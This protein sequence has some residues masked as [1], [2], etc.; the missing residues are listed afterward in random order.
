MDDIF[1][2][3]KKEQFN[4]FQKKM[5][6]PKNVLQ[7][8]T[9][10]MIQTPN[11]PCF[12]VPAEEI[13]EEYVQLRLP[14]RVLLGNVPILAYDDGAY[15]VVLEK[16]SPLPPDAT[17]QTNWNYPVWNTD[18]LR[19]LHYTQ[20]ANPWDELKIAGVVRVV[21]P[22]STD[23]KK[24]AKK[25][26]I[27]A[28]ATHKCSWGSIDAA[29]YLKKQEYEP[30]HMPLQLVTCYMPATTTN[31]IELT[32][33]LVSI[34]AGTLFD[35]VS[36]RDYTG[37]GRT[38][39]SAIK[40]GPILV[41]MPH[42]NDKDHTL[43]DR[44]QLWYRLRSFGML[45]LEGS[46]LNAWTCWMVGFQSSSSI[47][48]TKDVPM[49]RKREDDD[50]V[51]NIETYTERVEAQFNGNAGHGWQ[52]KALSELVG[53]SATYHAYH[54]NPTN[55]ICTELIA[56][57][58]KHLTLTHNALAKKLKDKI[59]Q[60]DCDTFE[61]ATKTTPLR[62]VYLFDNDVKT[63]KDNMKTLQDVKHFLHDAKI[64]IIESELYTR[65]DVMN[66]LGFGL[67]DTVR[68]CD[69]TN[70][71]DSNCLVVL[72]NKNDRKAHIYAAALAFKSAGDVIDIRYM[73]CKKGYERYGAP[74][75]LLLHLLKTDDEGRPKHYVNYTLHNFDVLQNDL[76]PCMWYYHEITIRKLIKLSFVGLQFVRGC[77]NESMHLS[78][79]DDHDGVTK[80]NF[81]STMEHFILYKEN[82]DNKIL[83]SK[84]VLDTPLEKISEIFTTNLKSEI[85]QH[86]KELDKNGFKKGILDIEDKNGSVLGPYNMINLVSTQS[87][88]MSWVKFSNPAKPL[89]T[90]DMDESSS[91]IFLTQL[92]TTNVITQEAMLRQLKMVTDG[93]SYL[94][95]AETRKM[96]GRVR[97]LYYGG[98]GGG[99]PHTA[100]RQ[101]EPTRFNASP[102]YRAGPATATMTKTDILVKL[103]ELYRQ[104]EQLKLQWNEMTNLQAESHKKAL[105]TEIFHLNNLL[106][107]Q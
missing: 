62:D 92:D 22:H 80:P 101:P 9:Q 38:A 91:H 35:S 87:T 60:L 46:V 14:K 8:G 30:N 53:D 19:N 58:T 69:F 76:D 100:F 98:L 96:H 13:P 73:F 97:S 65:T 6:D 3:N 88:N 41:E 21:S 31:H 107:N 18:V 49:L 64:M 44:K 43:D 84:E 42:L 11:N 83:K 70:S 7:R 78:S 5:A 48:T 68:T 4:I 10:Y 99:G 20:T 67:I 93:P 77:F 23:G 105:E 40:V 57:E 28:H 59:S 51:Y 56:R 106:L 15:M 32:S 12:I 75:L 63:L 39:S 16:D 27:E 85:Q 29:K 37:S 34:A 72:Y 79:Y 55:E 33:R 61:L 94:K 54:E 71:D 86:I 25:E 17:S 66:A 74:E 104:L 90:A 82:A 36:S 52:A 47:D 1:T 24:I 50:G 45:E 2:N 89:L 81:P 95:G 26:N 102:I 103:D